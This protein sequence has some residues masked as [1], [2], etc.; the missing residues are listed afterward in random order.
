MMS[1]TASYLN[2]TRA[3]LLPQSLVRHDRGIA[4]DELRE[5]SDDFSFPS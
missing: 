3:L 5:S 1:G 2:N 4:L